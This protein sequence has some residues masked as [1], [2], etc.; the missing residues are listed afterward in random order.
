[1]HKSGDLE[2][3]KVEMKRGNETIYMLTKTRWKG[4]GVYMSNIYRVLVNSFGKFM[5]LVYPNYVT[6]DN[7]P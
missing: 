7:N 4:N 2:N 1:M 3:N 6:C 5:L